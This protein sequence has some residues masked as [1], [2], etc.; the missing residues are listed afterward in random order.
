MRNEDTK[1]FD[2]L[3][4]ETYTVPSAVIGMEG[5]KAVLVQT[6]TCLPLSYPSLFVDKNV[7]YVAKY[8]S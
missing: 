6:D 7:I 1:L 3:L 2:H 8:M 4:L 5:H